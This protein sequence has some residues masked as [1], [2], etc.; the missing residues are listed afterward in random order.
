[1]GYNRLKSSFTAGEVSPLTFCRTDFDRYK[2]GCRKLYNAIC[3]SQ[4]PATNRSGTRFIYDI[5]ALDYDANDPK[6]R[7]VPFIFSETQAYVLIFYKHSSGT[8]KLIFGTSTGLVVYSA[9]PP[10]ECP[11]TM[12]VYPPYT[13]GDIVS[14]DLPAEWD[15]D[16]FD[17]AQSADELYFAQLTLPPHILIRHSNECWELVDATT[18]MTDMPSDWS[19]VYGWP[20]KVVFHQQRLVFAA[21]IIRGNTV[22]LS[23]AG[24]FTHFGKLDVTLVDADAVAFTLASG[25]QNNIVWLGSGKA[26]FAGTVGD[27]WTIQGS[28]QPAL[29]PN[30]ILALRQTNNGSEA[31]KPVMVGQST[32][33]VEKHGRRINE[34]VY[35][36]TMDSYKTSDLSIVSPHVTDDYSITD[37]AFQQTPDNIIWSIR[38]DGDLLGLTYQRDHKVIG[39]HH[40]DTEGAFLNIACIPGS[41]REDQ[42]F[43][44][45]KRVIDGVD[46]Y[47][48]E[49]L[50]DRFNAED[51]EWGRFLDS[52][53]VYHSTAVSQLSGLDHLE[54]KTVGILVDGLV[55]PDA[56]VTNGTVQFDGAYSHIVV[57]LKYES[58]IR[59]LL[60][61]PE[62]QQYGS[63]LGRMQ[64][65]TS[66]AINMYRSLGCTIGRV[67]SED[68]ETE[69]LVP[70]RNVSDAYV[71]Q[72]PL[73][74]GWIKPG[75]LEGFDVESQYFIK[76]TQPLPMTI[77]AITDTVEVHES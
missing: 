12:P 14:V 45:V 29:T 5:S 66:L 36:Y 25:T 44:M 30:N 4:G 53:V 56:V 8:I 33:F 10:T 61:D 15:I 31:I 23:R 58:E 65:I 13:P 75:Y 70:F 41:T 72:I 60:H 2:N 40:H 20:S 51:A 68:G 62:T 48:F 69:E 64:R 42:V 63:T 24:D 26:L 43:F 74:S 39:W 11:P 19:G 27:E 35:D 3:L 55:H 1:M 46:K 73:L 32:L 34:F 9:N 59:P 16:A 22:W 37:W 49:V 76:Q 38:A 50:E 6:F 18:A 71:E 57:G 77:R 67:D 7:L 28:S 54:G 21:T 17:W 47:Y 52:H